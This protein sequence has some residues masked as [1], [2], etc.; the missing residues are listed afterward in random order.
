MLTSGTDYTWITIAATLPCDEGCAS[1]RF[2]FNQFEREFS[3]PVNF[4]SGS[5]TAPVNADPA[6]PTNESPSFTAPVNV[7]ITPGHSFLCSAINHPITNQC[8]IVT[9][10]R[11]ERDVGGSLSSQKCVQLLHFAAA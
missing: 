7:V 9:I 5:F 11:P 4:L 8:Q 10:K 2:D 6:R 3:A 1:L